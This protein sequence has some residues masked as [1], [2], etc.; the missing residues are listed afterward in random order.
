MSGG[1][2]EVYDDINGKD[3]NFSE[4]LAALKKGH[5]ISLKKWV[6]HKY[7][8]IQVGRI[9]KDLITKIAMSDGN[10][11]YAWEPDSDAILSDEWLIAEDEFDLLR[12]RDMS[13][14]VV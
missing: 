13:K 14:S 9:G 7:L 5:K 10:D 4:A 1:D 12:M 2:I 11:T 3:K 8:I 6:H